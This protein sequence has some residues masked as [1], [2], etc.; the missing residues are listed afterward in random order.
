RGALYVK[1]TI[2]IEYARERL[3]LVLVGLHQTGR[4]G[5]SHAHSTPG[6]AVVAAAAVSTVAA[7]EVG[8]DLEAT[9]REAHLAPAQVPKPADRRLDRI[10]PAP[11]AHP[12]EASRPGLHGSGPQRYNYCCAC[13]GRC[14][15]LLPC[16]QPPCP[17]QRRSLPR[18][19]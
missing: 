18:P 16:S 9:L 10:G 17:A 13:A 5:L 1:S 15:L 2:R 14:W 8:P 4:P 12:S 19:L 7:Y 11:P 6:L 3:V